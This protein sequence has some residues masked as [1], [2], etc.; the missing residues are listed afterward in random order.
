MLLSRTQLTK[1]LQPS[2]KKAWKS[3]SNT[4]KSK[5]HNLKIPKAI[6]TTIQRLVSSLHSLASFLPLNSKPRRA[7]TRSYSTSYCQVHLKNFAAI[8]IDELF[9]NKSGYMQGKPSS[10]KG[11][12]VIREKESPKESSSNI[13]TI[14][15]AWKVVVARSPALQVDE[16]AEEFINKFRRD[17]KLQ[18]EM[19]LLEFQQRLARSA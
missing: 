19:S 7:L 13:D 10:G 15:D 16:K 17:M 12:E 2:K 9:A 18:K 11:K 4:L 1:K 8:R 14:E 6:N 3:F 5:V